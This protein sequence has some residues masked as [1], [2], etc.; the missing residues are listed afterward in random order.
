M[1]RASLLSLLQLACRQRWLP[2]RHTI[3]RQLLPPDRIRNSTFATPFFGSIYRGNLNNEIDWHVFFFGSYAPDELFLLRD[4]AEYQKT[5]T[6]NDVVFY[7]VG[8]NVGNHTLF[9]SAI[10]DHV[11]AFEPYPPLADILERQLTY[12][13]ISTASVL[14]VGLGDSEASLPYF[15]PPPG[16]LGVGSVVQEHNASLLPSGEIK[17]A[18]GDTLV[19]SGE[20][21]EPTLLK[22]DVE[23]YEGAVLA[24]MQRVLH[25]RRPPLL[26]E[27][28]ETSK[29]W[30]QSLDALKQLL[31][32]SAEFYEIRSRYRSDY[33][34]G[35]YDFHSSK[36]VLVLPEEYVVRFSAK[37]R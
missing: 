21:R 12:N 31:Y 5:L 19:A 22:I 4:I 15:A 6:G 1:T 26:L 27:I 20:I 17:V 37:T 34:L 11:Y 2:Y 35:P 8:A 16:N 25:A 32:A 36:R 28:S 10:A 24:G 9:M 13:N 14:R 30:I 29:K 33:T 18:R 7:D 23:G 3:M